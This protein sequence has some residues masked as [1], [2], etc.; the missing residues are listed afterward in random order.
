MRHKKFESLIVLKIYNETSPEEE[1]KL[2]GHLSSCGSCR[3]FMESLAQILPSSGAAQRFSLD[4]SLV[5]SRKEF[6][7]ALADER[8][9]LLAGGRVRWSSPGP[10][11]ILG[12]APAFAMTAVVLFTFILGS[13]TTYFFMHRAASS[14]Q[15]G[16]YVLSELSMKN[17]GEAGIKD[18]N[19]VSTDPK[20]GEVE[21]SFD[22]VKRYNMRGSLDDQN[23]QKVLAY[24][25]VNSDNAGTRLRTIGM[26]DASAAAKPD[27]MIRQALIKAARSDDNA[28]VRR[29]ALLSLEK[30]PFDND[31]RD[32]VLSVL[33]GDK[34]PG[35]RVAAINFLSEKELTAGSTSQ[36][37]KKIDPRVLNV[38]K[39]K[40]STDQNRYVR[41]KASDMLKELMEL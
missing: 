22:F 5:E 26:V 10:R 24:A 16:E 38:L 40:S 3:E 32:A 13:G 27:A 33:Q 15:G 12:L 4:E 19:F 14:A 11:H 9:E 23:V 30:L 2:E 6:R 31:I 25:L 8:S 34:N 21:F 35:M 1:S 17:P 41:L 39:E 7:R 28:G 18:I 37:T 20:T 36:G 29:E